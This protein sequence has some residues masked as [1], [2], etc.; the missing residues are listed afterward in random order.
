[1]PKPLCHTNVNKITIKYNQETKPHTNQTLFTFCLTRHPA[2]QL[3]LLQSSRTTGD[4]GSYR[5]ADM[6]ISIVKRCGY[7]IVAHVTPDNIVSRLASHVTWNRKWTNQRQVPLSTVRDLW[8]LRMHLGLTTVKPGLH[9]PSWRPVNSGAFFWH[10][11]TRVSKNVPE[12]TGRQLDPWTRVV[13][14]RL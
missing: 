4:Y 11:S 1:M 8:G 3:H 7:D 9:Y 2:A 10:P 12:F 6:K 13:E 5:L 14:T